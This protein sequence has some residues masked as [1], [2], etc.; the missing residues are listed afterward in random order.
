M[1]SNNEAHRYRIAMLF[2]CSAWN[3]LSFLGTLDCEKLE[4][5]GLNYTTIDARWKK[6]HINEQSRQYKKEVQK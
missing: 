3:G 1:Q 5:L 4:L 6:G 2:L